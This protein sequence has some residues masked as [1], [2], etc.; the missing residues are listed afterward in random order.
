MK[1]PK[2]VFGA[3]VG[4]VLV[5]LNVWSAPE[6][7]EPKADGRERRDLLLLHLAVHVPGILALAAYERG[8]RLYFGWWTLLRKSQEEKKGNE[9]PGRCEKVLYLC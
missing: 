3:V 6:P 1:F 4:S 9:G 8:R 2:A 7:G 5:F